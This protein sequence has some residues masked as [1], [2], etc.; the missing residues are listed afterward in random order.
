MQFF[1]DNKMNTHVFATQIKNKFNITSI[2][3][4]SMVPCLIVSPSFHLR[5]YHY[6]EIYVYHSP[7]FP[8]VYT[9][10]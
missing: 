2:F 10:Y 3:E 9:V 5:G 4:V 8:L 1:K 7:A 6:P